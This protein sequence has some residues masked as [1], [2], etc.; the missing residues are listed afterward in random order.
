MHASDMRP[1]ES[2]GLAAVDTLL[3]GPDWR[4]DAACKGM[5]DLFFP[6]DP[7]APAAQAMLEQARQICAECA[8]RE[9]CAR[10][11]R[12]E[13]FGVWGGLSA[14]ERRRARRRRA[15]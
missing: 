9:R 14:P 15:A 12:R 1:N 3:H 4:A 8:V 10:A 5:T 6:E 7:S 2:T 11:G 13:K